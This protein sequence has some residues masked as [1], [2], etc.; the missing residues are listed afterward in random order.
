M[1]TLI[2]IYLLLKS[3]RGRTITHL[4]SRVAY[5]IGECDPG[6]PEWLRVIANLEQDAALPEAYQLFLV[7]IECWIEERLAQ[8][9][10][11]IDGWIG[12]IDGWIEEWMR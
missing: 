2:E 4:D 6:A 12:W 10:D 7:G 8:I 3:A 9:C 11:R 1:K 5:A